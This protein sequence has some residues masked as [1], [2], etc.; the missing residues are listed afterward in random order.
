MNKIW[1]SFTKEVRPKQRGYVQLPNQTPN[2][3]QLGKDAEEEDDDT[4]LHGSKQWTMK[5][6]LVWASLKFGLNPQLRNR[7]EHQVKNSANTPEAGVENENND[8]NDEEITP[9]EPEE[10]EEG[11]EDHQDEN[12]EAKEKKETD[13]MEEANSE[14]LGLLEDAPAEE[15]EEEE[16]END[17]PLIDVDDVKGREPTVEV[18]GKGGTSSATGSV[19]PDAVDTL[20]WDD[21]WFEAGSQPTKE[22]VVAWKEQGYKFTPKELAAFNFSPDG[23]P[24]DVKPGKRLRQDTGEG[25][26]NAEKPHEKVEPGSSHTGEEQKQALYTVLASDDEADKQAFKARDGGDDTE[27]LRKEPEHELHAVA[28]AERISSGLAKDND[29]IDIG[30]AQ[31]KMRKAAREEEQE[32]EDPDRFLREAEEASD[33]SDKPRRGRGRG[34]GKG[35]GRG[36]GGRKGTGDEHKGKEDDENKATAETEEKPTKKKKRNQETCDEQ[37]K[38]DKAHKKRSKE[39]KDK[40]HSRKD[41]PNDDSKEGQ[42]KMSPALNLDIATSNEDSEEVD[43]MSS[44]GTKG[45][46]EKPASKPKKGS[47]KVTDSPFVKK[48]RENRQRDKA[49]KEVG[50]HLQ[51][52]VLKDETEKQEQNKTKKTKKTNTDA[53]PAVRNLDQ[54][55]K[56]AEDGVEVGADAEPKQGLNKAKEDQR[57]EESKPDKTPLKVRRAKQRAETAEARHN[58]S[59][60]IYAPDNLP[61]PA[62]DGAQLLAY[63]SFYV[64]PVPKD[65]PRVEK[66]NAYLQLRWTYAQLLAGWEAVPES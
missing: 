21:Y 20:S 12:H 62:K 39:R 54:E 28:S 32:A 18:V 2:D 36:R 17:E 56:E 16:K 46:P 47:R 1:E 8:D 59:Y 22:D 41:E 25:P 65:I 48:T 60:T 30:Q 37:A 61:N 13:E 49:E 66:V 55:F 43:V 27:P 42:Q 35:R 58:Q 6:A 24:S 45:T 5:E 19:H 26:E 33:A 10:S 15:P 11:E 31:K 57:H 50:K 34:R 38:E 3:R 23:M 9:T 64:Y 14:E 44:K 4:S 7:A 52:M 40:E 53:D 29:M 51:K 63:R